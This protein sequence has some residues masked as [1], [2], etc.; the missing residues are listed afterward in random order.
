MALLYN[1][2]E[3]WHIRSKSKGSSTNQKTHGSRSR[4][5]ES[6]PPSFMVY[7]SQVF[8]H[9]IILGWISY[10]GCPCLDI[11]SPGQWPIVDGNKTVVLSTLFFLYQKHRLIQSIKKIIYS[12]PPLVDASNA[13]TKPQSLSPFIQIIPFVLVIPC[14]P[15]RFLPD[16]RPFKQTPPK[17]C[18]VLNEIY[19]FSTAFALLAENICCH[20]SIHSRCLCESIFCGLRTISVTISRTRML[21]LLNASICFQSRTENRKR[22]L[23][24]EIIPEYI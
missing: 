21:N 24:I 20:I 12:N 3:A 8:I 10:K 22:L 2:F 5:D 19:F 11:L 9:M 14:V 18:N 23:S 15:S 1:M 13:I 16:P 17:Q 7:D 4:S 6:S